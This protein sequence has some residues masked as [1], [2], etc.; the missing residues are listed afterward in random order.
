M[1]WWF[2]VIL[3]AVNAILTMVTMS[4]DRDL[5]QVF[6]WSGMLAVVGLFLRSAAE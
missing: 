5:A 6:F 2:G 1:M 4:I 3:A